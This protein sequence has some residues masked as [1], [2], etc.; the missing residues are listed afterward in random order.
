MSMHVNTDKR[1][2]E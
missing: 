2:I 1:N